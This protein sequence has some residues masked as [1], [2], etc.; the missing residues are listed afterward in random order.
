MTWTLFSKGFAQ[1]SQLIKKTSHKNRVPE[2]GELPKTSE[3]TKLMQ[4]TSVEAV[5]AEN[6]PPGKD[7]N[8][9]YGENQ[10]DDNRSD[11]K[12]QEPEEGNIMPPDA[13]PGNIFTLID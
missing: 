1:L 13:P 2:S 9:K 3:F 7:S 12:Y 5:V 11:D 10:D 4:N 6:G 8:G